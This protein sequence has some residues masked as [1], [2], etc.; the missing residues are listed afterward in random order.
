MSANIEQSAENTLSYDLTDDLTMQVANKFEMHEMQARLVDCVKQEMAIK[1]ANANAQTPFVD[2]ADF[3]LRGLV[4]VKQDVYVYS[5]SGHN[6]KI[7]VPC[8]Y[9][10]VLDVVRQ[11]RSMPDVA[12]REQEL[13]AHNYGNRA[14]PEDIV[15]C[16]DMLPD[17]NLIPNVFLFDFHNP[18]DA[19]VRQTYQNGFISQAAIEPNHDVMFFV[20]DNDQYLFKD[21]VHEWAHAL[22][23]TLS[24]EDL[25]LLDAA[26]E[27]ERGYYVPLFYMLRSYAEHMAILAE[28]LLGTS[29]QLF[30]DMAQKA[31]VRTMAFFEVLRNVL[32]NEAHPRS[33]CFDV[34]QKRLLHVKQAI[35]KR[36]EEFLADKQTKI[37]ALQKKTTMAV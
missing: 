33:I 7:I 14:L 4:F 24:Q 2:Y 5:V 23:D 26:I 17:S 27:L 32:G 25:N 37:T 30:I 31:P 18:E 36:A 22:R 34:I 13:K 20:R 9:A 10:L 29:G 8:E 11:I 19:W 21:M 6:T 16:L 15:L 12:Q 3:C 1:T 35:A 28:H